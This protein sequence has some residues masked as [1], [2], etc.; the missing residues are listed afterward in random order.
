VPITKMKIKHT[1]TEKYNSN[2]KVSFLFNVNFMVG[3]TSLLCFIHRSNHDR[4]L[5]TKNP[6]EKERNF[7]NCNTF[8]N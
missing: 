7:I 8:K 1:V 2:K 6:T 3:L 4:K 5:K